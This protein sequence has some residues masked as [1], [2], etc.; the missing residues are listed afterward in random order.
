MIRS[1]EYND[2]HQGYEAVTDEYMLGRDILVCPVITKGTVEKD[3][4]FPE[5]RWQDEKGTVYEGRQILKLPTP[6]DNLLW[7]RRV[8][9]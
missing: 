1:L 6:L 9:D 2:P 3:I 8:K 7:F 4:V 5:G